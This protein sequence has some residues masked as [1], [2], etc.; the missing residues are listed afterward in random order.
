MF[1]KRCG[2]FKEF[3]KGKHHL[4]IADIDH[5]HYNVNDHHQDIFPERPTTRFT[6]TQTISQC[7]K[8]FIVNLVGV[9]NKLCLKSTKCSCNVNQALQCIRQIG[10]PNQHNRIDCGLFAVMNCLHILDGISICEDIYLLN[11]IYHIQNILPSMLVQEKD[12]Q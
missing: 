9:L 5:S 8:Y 1:K 3:G 2:S 4:I 7:I 12:E 6:N 10:C 11:N